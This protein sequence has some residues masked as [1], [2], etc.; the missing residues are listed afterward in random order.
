M[1][2]L[3]EIQRLAAQ[4]TPL[5]PH[6][7]TLI[8]ALDDGTAIPP[9]ALSDDHSI[10]LYGDVIPYLMRQSLEGYREIEVAD[11][12]PQSIVTAGPAGADVRWF[13]EYPALRGV[14][15]RSE[16]LQYLDEGWWAVTP[17]VKYPANTVLAA[18]H[19]VKALYGAAH[20]YI[21]AELPM[22]LWIRPAPLA[23]DTPGAQAV[24]QARGENRLLPTNIHT[25]CP[26][27]YARRWAETARGYYRIAASA[28]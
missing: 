10:G 1:D 26:M 11:L 28:E 25:E 3:S 13:L 27:A 18:L 22:P 9:E 16:R 19:A 23:G 12:L 20:L 7:F 14:R 21:N 8:T 24:I 2:T 6:L 15:F 17:E 5:V 4:L